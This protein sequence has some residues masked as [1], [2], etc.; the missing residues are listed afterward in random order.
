[1][2]V[3]DCPRSKSRVFDREQMGDKKM[4]VFDSV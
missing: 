2:S 4:S 1:M 3:Y